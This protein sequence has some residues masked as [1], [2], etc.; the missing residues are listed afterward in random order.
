MDRLNRRDLL[1]HATM[2]GAVAMTSKPE[3][4]AAQAQAGAAAPAADTTRFALTPL[5]LLDVELRG[6]RIQLVQD[7][8]AAEADGFTLD[9]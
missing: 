4:S 8:I 1:R 9:L 2:L 6:Q 7:L 5:V 3:P